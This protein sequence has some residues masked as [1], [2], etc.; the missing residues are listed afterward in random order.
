MGMNIEVKDEENLKSDKPY[1]LICNHQ[2]ELDCIGMSMYKL[3]YIIIPIC[4]TV[5]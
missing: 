3:V 4:R 5:Q 2:S 1:V